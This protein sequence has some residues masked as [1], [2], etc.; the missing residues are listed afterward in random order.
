MLKIL[1]ITFLLLANS[2][3]GQNTDPQ[4]F[5]ML[6]RGYNI[7]GK[8]ASQDS[9]GEQLIEY[10]PKDLKISK[11]NESEIYF[12]SGEDVESYSKKLGAS[13]GL[14]GNN[15]YFKGEFKA[16]YSEDVATSKN[17][18][19]FKLEALF[20]TET[21]WLRDDKIKLIPKAKE[22]LYKLSPEE[23]FEK[24][25]THYLKKAS[26]GAKLSQSSSISK[27]TY[28]NIKDFNATAK[29]SYKGS[30][31]SASA[32]VSTSLKEDVKK[33]NKEVNWKL[34]TKGGE[35]PKSF[36]IYNNKDYETWVKSIDNATSFV[37]MGS[38]SLVPIW[39]LIEDDNDRK[40]EISKAFNKYAKDNGA[41]YHSGYSKFDEY[42]VPVYG[43]R[44]QKEQFEDDARWYFT[45]VDDANLDGKIWKRY[46][47]KFYAF[48][49]KVLKN[50]KLA[51]KVKPIYRYYSKIEYS[52][53]KPDKRSEPVRYTL[54]DRKGD[55]LDK[56]WFRDGKNPVFYVFKK[57]EE[58]SQA[59]YQYTHSV[60][61]R[62]SGSY[63][64]TGTNTHDWDFMGRIFYVP[65]VE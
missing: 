11:D 21:A 44:V 34:I 38:N 9:L 12:V 53:E 60:E 58:D 28:K 48:N 3:L 49:E 15:F 2:L 29:A 46:S 59:I 27:D 55:T 65:K 17:Y 63:F 23:L 4:R 36:Y 51:R 57:K 19:Y 56:V 64:A 42:I 22:D 62:K 47:P 37:Y 5:N 14:E 16:D 26:I 10:I 54:S 61:G 7:F 41:F 40:N 24:Y 25:G 20:I 32:E 1:I 31:S 39:Y 30:I 43:Y 50:K 35:S 45:T 18:S 8:M 52:K 6:G 33:F 13:V